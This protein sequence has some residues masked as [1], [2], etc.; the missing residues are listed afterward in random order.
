MD[1]VPLDGQQY[2]RQKFGLILVLNWSK[3]IRKSQLTRTGQ[4][5]AVVAYL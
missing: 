4:R 3:N 2:I 5:Y 1:S